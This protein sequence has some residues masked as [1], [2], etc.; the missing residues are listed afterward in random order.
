M[1]CLCAALSRGKR[2]GR[3]SV[4]PSAPPLSVL[5]FRRRASKN[6]RAACAADGASR[7]LP[8][9][10]LESLARA[11]RLHRCECDNFINGLTTKNIGEAGCA[12]KMTHGLDGPKLFCAPLKKGFVL[13]KYI[14]MLEVGPARLRL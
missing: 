11:R 2:E 1:T 4:P 9:T 5:A 8:I 12:K 7:T 14:P 6:A 3:A 10:E 13:S